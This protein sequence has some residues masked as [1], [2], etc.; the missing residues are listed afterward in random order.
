[1]TS[2]AMM[3]LN[4]SDRPY[5]SWLPVSAL[6]VAAVP[7]VFGLLAAA[8][9]LGE[10]IKAYRFEQ[11]LRS[12]NLIIGLAS[13][14]GGLSLAVGVADIRNSYLTAN[15]V[16]AMFWAFFSIQLAFFVVAVAASTWTA[17]PYRA[18]WR[19]A[20]RGLRRT[21]R[22]YLKTRRSVARLAGR[23]NGLVIQHRTLVARAADGV[24]AAYSDGTR[25]GHLYLRGHQHGLPEPVTGELCPGPIPQPELGRPVQELQ[26]YPNVS[27]SGNLAP[28]ELAT[29]DDLDEA[30][31]RLLHR[32]HVASTAWQAGESAIEQISS[33]PLN[34]AGKVQPGKGLAATTKAHG[35]SR[36][37][38]K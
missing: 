19:Q 32:L 13:L 6:Q 23:V 10:S 38:A 4:I 27:P 14:G 28:L 22:R 7:V 5:V 9:F 2:V 20:A 36:P 31:E 30:W 8:H 25:Q 34:G 18:E 35:T 11:R 37:G 29:V 17:H 24:A 1:M 26:G 3:V 33:Y 15:G 12:V 21:I 16:P